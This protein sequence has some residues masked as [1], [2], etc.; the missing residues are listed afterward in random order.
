[1]MMSLN[2]SADVDSSIADHLGSKFQQADAM[3]SLVCTSA[4]PDGQPDAD[5][6]K[7][8][9]FFVGLIPSAT[10]GINSVLSFQVSPEITFVFEK[11]E[12]QD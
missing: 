1:M 7:F 4:A 8:T 12:I 11:V 2:A 9:Q 3:A 5:D 10:F 6:V